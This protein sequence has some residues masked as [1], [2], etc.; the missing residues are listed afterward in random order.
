MAWIK[1]LVAGPNDVAGCGLVEETV[2]PFRLPAAGTGSRVT[3]CNVETLDLKSAVSAMSDVPMAKIKMQ[4]ETDDEVFLLW[5]AGDKPAAAPPS[6]NIRAHVLSARYKGHDAD[7]RGR[8]DCQFFSPLI[9]FDLE[10]ESP[11]Q[12]GRHTDALAPSLQC[13]ANV[14]S[15]KVASSGAAGFPLSLY[16]S[17]LVKDALDNDGICLFR[18]ERDDPQIITSQDE[19]LLLTGPTRGLVA[20]DYLDFEVDLKLKTLRVEDDVDFSQ[21]TIMHNCIFDK[22]PFISNKLE[23]PHSI[24]ELNYAPVGR[25]LEST[26]EVKILK[27]S[28]QEEDDG[29]MDAFVGGLYGKISA[30]NSGLSEEIVL[31]DSEASGVAIALGDDGVLKLSR[32]VVAVPVRDSLVVTVETWAGCGGDDLQEATMKS[33][34]TFMPLLCGEGRAIVPCARHTMQIRVFWSA[35]YIPFVDP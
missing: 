13:S 8:V 30:R 15:V 29:N 4:A 25:A 28:T 16:G 34:F 22:S 31:F 2:T 5:E 23:S 11:L 17:I 6:S 20:F 18:R 33:S 14:L 9:D 21:G 3:P 10:E 1:N 12:P 7:T 24:L 19:S 26:V 27:D 35:L 32:C